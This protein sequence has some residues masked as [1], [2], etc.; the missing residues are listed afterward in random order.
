MAAKS[1]A[2]STV[3]SAP[4]HRTVGRPLDTGEVHDLTGFH[5]EHHDIAVV[6]PQDRPTKANAELSGAQRI[7]I[8]IELYSLDAHLDTGRCSVSYPKRRRRC[9]RVGAS[10]SHVPSGITGFRR[11]G[12]FPDVVT[13][14]LRRPGEASASGP[15][16]K[17]G[18][19]R[20]EQHRGQYQM[21]RSRRIRQFH[22]DGFISSNDIT[23]PR[24]PSRE[25]GQS[26]VGPSA[27]RFVPVLPTKRAEPSST[28]ADTSQRPARPIS[29]L[30]MLMRPLLTWMT[31]GQLRIDPRF[32]ARQDRTELS[33]RNAGRRD[34]RAGGDEQV[35][36]PHRA[37]P[38]TR[39]RPP[40]RSHAPDRR[41]TIS[42]GQS[43]DRTPRFQSPFRDHVAAIGGASKIL[44][45]L[46]LASLPRSAR[47]PIRRC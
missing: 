3:Q 39:C 26:A 18:D 45:R 31:A 28:T 14:S 46:L 25:I 12:Q 43:P 40:G 4:M 44:F 42:R 33:G 27:F 16:H 15:T 38:R 8:P 6:Q 21:D 2:L 37:C 20:A 34:D 41:R 36:A 13:A 29:L 9:A 1:P 23:A 24:R 11:R 30:M 7:V 47:G 35:G 22:D 5:V 10:A 32:A 17:R 19:E